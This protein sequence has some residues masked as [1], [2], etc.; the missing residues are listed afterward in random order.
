M[1][2]PAIVVVVAVVAL[3]GL[4][5]ASLR[6]EIQNQQDLN[7]LKTAEIRRL[8]QQLAELKKARREP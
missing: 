3:L 5:Y 2:A 1:M 7:D 4:A 6:K 8:E